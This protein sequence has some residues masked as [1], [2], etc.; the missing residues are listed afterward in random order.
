MNVTAKRTGDR[1]T[2]VVSLSR[3][4]PRGNVLR[5]GKRATP[6][7]LERQ[8]ERVWRAMRDRTRARALGKKAIAK[9]VKF[10]VSS[11]VLADLVSEG[12]LK[13]VGNRR[14]AVYWSKGR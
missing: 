4:N 8:R 9:L 12:S 13:M 7:E 14:A 11:N 5:K 3:S 6:Y 1:I 10:H 2:I